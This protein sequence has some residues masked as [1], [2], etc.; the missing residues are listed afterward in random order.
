MTLPSNLTTLIEQVNN[1]L[2]ALDREL[3]QTLG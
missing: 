3:A 1:E 2:N